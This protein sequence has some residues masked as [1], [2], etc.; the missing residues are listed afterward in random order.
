[1]LIVSL[2]LE[3]GGHP[4]HGGPPESVFDGTDRR[5]VLFCKADFPRGR[6]SSSNGR[7]LSTAI[8]PGKFHPPEAPV[9][10]LI[11]ATK[12]SWRRHGGQ[13]GGSIGIFQSGVLLREPKSVYRKSISKVES[14]VF[15]RRGAEEK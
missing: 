1:M 2:R 10:F 6:G 15:Q 5:H 3:I 9:S 8:Q 7:K 12:D 11:G 14:A 13:G 4:L